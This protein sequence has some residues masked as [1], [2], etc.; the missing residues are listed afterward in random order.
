M[1]VWR[2]WIFVDV[3]CWATNDIGCMASNYNCHV[4]PSH[5]LIK[6]SEIGC[7]WLTESYLGI[8]NHTGLVRDGR[9]CK[10]VPTAIVDPKRSKLGGKNSSL[11]LS[12]VKTSAATCLMRIRFLSMWQKRHMYSCAYVGVYPRVFSSYVFLSG[13]RVTLRV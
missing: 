5:H 1:C 7:A 10:D 9:Y 4:M 8:F 6:T 3:V 13:D 2:G 12:T 11:S